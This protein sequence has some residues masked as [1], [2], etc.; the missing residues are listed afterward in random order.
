MVEKGMLYDSMEYDK[1]RQVIQNIHKEK[2]DLK[3]GE[4]MAGFSRKDLV[5]PVRTVVIYYGK[6]P[7]LYPMKLSDIWE[8]T[9]DLDED[10]MDYRINV[11]DVRRLTEEQIEGIESDVRLLFGCIKYDEE[12]EKMREFVEKNRKCF[13]NLTKETFTVIA[14]MTN[15]KILQEKVNEWEKGGAYNMCKAFEEWRK[16]DRRIGYEEGRKEGILALIETYKELGGSRENAFDNLKKK[17][18]LNDEE[19]EKYVQMY[20]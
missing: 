10:L 6:E 20:W 2:G 15:S 9:E 7:W 16:E 18:L 19:C 14:V 4:F 1:Q 3:K 17:F 13:E 11:L 8:C 12:P 5:V